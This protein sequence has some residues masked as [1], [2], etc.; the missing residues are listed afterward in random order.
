MSEVLSAI[1]EETYS[2]AELAGDPGGFCGLPLSAGWLAVLGAAAAIRRR[3]ATVAV[4]GLLAPGV[5]A[6]AP[7][8]DDLTPR[9]W[10]VAL[11]YGPW[12]QQDEYLGAAFGDTGNQMFRMDYGWASQFVEVELGVGLYRR[13][14]FLLTEDGSVSSD[15]DTF[16]IIPLGL[17]A[18]GRLDFF[19]EQP[20]V[21]F[22]RIGADYWI[23]QEAWDVGSAD[24]V[25]TREGGKYGW[26][27]GFG[28]M[29]LLDWLDR[30]TASELE[31]NTGINDTYLVGEWRSSQIVSS[32]LDFTSTEVTFGLQFDF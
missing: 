32:G 29:I 8:D 5:A 22:A 21:P 31:A 19:A 17:D 16:M 3:V 11:R 24:D 26:H 7:K 23:W 28:A 15:P 1:P 4:L 25:D 14:G 6:A 18:V 30:G 13:D 2:A 20:L 12:F 10:N 9:N 27:Y